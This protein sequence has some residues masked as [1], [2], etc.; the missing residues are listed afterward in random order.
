[1]REHCVLPL[2]LNFG[3]DVGH[4]NVLTAV[5]HF[6]LLHV[7]RQQGVGFPGGFKGCTELPCD[8]WGLLGFSFRHSR[9]S[10]SVVLYC[11]LWGQDWCAYN[12]NLLQVRNRLLK[13][14][15]QLTPPTASWIASWSDVESQE[16]NTFWV[17]INQKVFFGIGPNL[18]QVIM[19]WNL[20]Y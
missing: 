4:W 15:I 7:M 1:M 5:L 9:W 3:I 12:S 13:L 20:Q 11:G 14:I 17:N 18:Q 10:T 19:G 8:T 16:I 2:P 6:R